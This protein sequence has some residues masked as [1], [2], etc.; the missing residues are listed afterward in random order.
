MPDK[1]IAI[2][3]GPPGSGKGTQAKL[4]AERFDLKYLGSGDT[5]RKR[6]KKPDFTGEK[7]AKVLEEGSLAPSFVVIKLLLDE[8][9]KFKEEKGFKGVVLDGWTR[10]LSEA[11]FLDEALSW[12]G[13]DR[14]TKAVFIRISPEESYN[15]LTKRRQCKKCGNIIPWVG[16][17]KEIE[18]CNKCEGEL[19]TRIDDNSDSIK[20]RLEEFEKET[21]PALEYYRKKEKLFEVDGERSIEKVFEDVLKIFT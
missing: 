18:R 16:E 13:W 4:L 17:F 15:R 3:I 12:Y 21:V 20:R 6:I 1:K 5:L 14:D 2:L 7:L 11:V 10:I 8:L 19:A 9:E